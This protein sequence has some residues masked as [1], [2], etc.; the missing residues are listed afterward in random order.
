[1]FLLDL[2]ERREAGSLLLN[3]EEEKQSSGFY[4]EHDRL[5]SFAH[6]RARRLTSAASC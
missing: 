2:A 1:V 3:S 6:G 4:F 5:R